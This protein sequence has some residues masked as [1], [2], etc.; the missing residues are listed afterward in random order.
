MTKKNVARF[1]ACFFAI[2]FAKNIFL[3]NINYIIDK[4]INKNIL[5]KIID[6][7]NYAIF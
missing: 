6:K 4:I 1:F 3:L 5:N 2:F 7:C